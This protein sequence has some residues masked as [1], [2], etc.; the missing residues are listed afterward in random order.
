MAG[1][2]YGVDI[3]SVQEIDR[4]TEI[5]A[6]PEAPAYVEGV[7]NLRGRITPIVNLS[8]RFGLPKAE[9]TPRTRHCGGQEW[10]GLGGAGRGWGV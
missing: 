5:T 8:S 2:S 6:I 7:I 9:V 3:S 1:E 10:R 4:M